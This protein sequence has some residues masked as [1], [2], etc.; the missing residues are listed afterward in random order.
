MQYKEKK[1]KEKDNYNDLG[2]YLNFTNG[3]KSSHKSDRYKNLT[4]TINILDEKLK[5]QEKNKN[6]SNS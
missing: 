2:N 6:C 5:E 1:E 3:V 4:K